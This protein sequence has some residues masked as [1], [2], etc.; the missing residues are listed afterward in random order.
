MPPEIHRY[1]RV[2]KGKPVVRV[3]Y[4][5]KINYAREEVK[6]EISGN[7]IKTYSAEDSEDKIYLYSSMD[8]EKVLNREEIELTEHHF[9]PVVI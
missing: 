1:I 5:P 9:F 2:I 7:Y 3:I 6:H 8:F 4:D